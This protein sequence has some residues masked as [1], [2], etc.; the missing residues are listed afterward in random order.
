MWGVLK[1]LTSTYGTNDPLNFVD[2]ESYKQRIKKYEK[3]T[4]RPSSVISGE[5]KIN[6]MPL[7]IVV[8]DFS[9]MGGV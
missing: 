9:F 1:S 8:F 4:N 6:R 7:Q 5:A 2:K 3:R